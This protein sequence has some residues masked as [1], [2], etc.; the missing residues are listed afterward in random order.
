MIGLLKILSILSILLAIAAIVLLGIYILGEKPALAGILTEQGAVAKFKAG[1]TAST[2]STDKIPPLVSQAK[3][4]ANKINPPEPVV[5]QKDPEPL[6]PLNG[7]DGLT[8]RPPKNPPPPTKFKLMAT[9]RYEDNPEKSLA[10]LDLSAKG[11]EW[12]R[13]GEDIEHYTLHEVKDGSVIL[14]QPGRKNTEL[15]MQE[16]ITE[17]LLKSDAQASATPQTPINRVRPGSRT[18]RP[19]PS[20]SRR[21]P[22]PRRTVLTSPAKPP[23]ILTPEQQK[24]QID[25]NIKG[26][27]NILSDVNQTPEEKKAM[28]QL[29]QLLQQDKKRI[30]DEAKKAPPG[31]Q[32]K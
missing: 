8:V 20:P 23:V 3:A 12:F 9:C 1:G 21:T 32:K 26:V 15:F 25:D 30:E 16:E 11:R 5:A 27:S 18:S 28:L 24:A 2:A 14:Y 4:F 6:Q 13:Q 29:I 7:D 19:I 10:L 31:G 22:T 17:S